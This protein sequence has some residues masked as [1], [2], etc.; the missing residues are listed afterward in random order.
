MYLL[1]NPSNNL[2]PSGL[3]TIDRKN[4]NKKATATSEKD[5]TFESLSEKI[6]LRTKEISFWLTLL[7]EIKYADGSE[8][9]LID[10]KKPL[11]PGQ[12]FEIPNSIIM[13]WL[14]DLGD[15]G[16]LG[17]GWNDDID[18]LKKLGFFTEVIEFRGKDANK[19]GANFITTAR[20]MSKNGE[21]HGITIWSHG[22]A[23]GFATKGG[24][25]SYSYKKLV[26]DLKYPLSY[27]VLN[28][29][30]GGW[31]KFSEK[32]PGSGRGNGWL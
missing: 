28:N 31:S 19:I 6:G 18:Y 17:V 21:L 22:N 27:V 5:D 24:E 15:V 32:K 26:D 14:G 8:S 11:C 3:W 7:G 2:D 20:D 4:K 12:K 1:D 25:I 29:C 23:G 30:C 13:L 9:I 16:Q 10:I